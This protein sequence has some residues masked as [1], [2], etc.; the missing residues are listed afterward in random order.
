M[1]GQPYI[2][3]MGWQQKDWVG[4]FY[5]EATKPADMLALYARRFSSVEVDTT[6]YGRPRE[7]TVDTWRDAV[8]EEFRFTLKVPREVT[9]RRRFEDAEQVF[10]LFVDRVRKLG[11]RLGAIL[12]Q[13]PRDF[14]P[15]PAN[16]QRL[17]SFLDALLPP[18]VNVALELRHPGWFDE[19]L[20][21]M[22]RSQR[23]ALAATEGPHSSLELAERILIE[24][25]EELDF[26]YIRLMGLTEFERYDRVQA[27]RAESLDVWARIIREARN[28]VR[29]VYISVSDD[30]AGFSPATVDDL[31]SRLR[32]SEQG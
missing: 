15:T 23:F 18:D 10:T 21:E 4:P 8:S 28:R 9:H 31:A 11:T 25:G 22:A 13:C 26:A 3:C 19:A 17:Y 2:G 14:S 5:P 20:F 29:A 16:R 12:I 1:A 27:D 24:Q 32:A 7:S 6:F 30:Y